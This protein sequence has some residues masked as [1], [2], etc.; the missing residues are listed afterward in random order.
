M[1]YRYLKVTN[2]TPILNTPNFQVVFGGDK[3]NRLKTDENGHIRALEFI[4]LKGMIFKIDHKTSYPY[5]Y[6]VK[7]SLYRESELYIDTRFTAFINTPTKSLMN[8][9]LDKKKIIKKLISYL[10]D[11]YLWGGNYSKGIDEILE[12]YP[13][14]KNLQKNQIDKW[15]L[16]GIDCSGILFEAT[17]GYTP[18]NTFQMLHYKKGLKIKN[19]T[20]SQ[21]V[22]LVKPL[23]IIVFKG[24]V[25]IVIDSDYT[26][27]SRENFG[28]IKFPIKDRLQEIHF[29]KKP[30]NF[31]KNENDY[32]IRRWL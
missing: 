11:E 3:Q 12:Y 23:D 16:K 18:R 14:A 10:G 29:S 24:H 9:N 31:Y 6:K 1:L 7:Y 5:I 26:I 30:S 21:I 17:N 15:I 13:P 22:D 32:V 28:V 27:E 8:Y 19:L 4:A 2:P 20:I 25:V